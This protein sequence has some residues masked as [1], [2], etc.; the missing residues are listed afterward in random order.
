MILLTHLLKYF[1]KKLKI[2][3]AIIYKM[4]EQSLNKLE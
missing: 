1:Y 2:E 4:L 3:I